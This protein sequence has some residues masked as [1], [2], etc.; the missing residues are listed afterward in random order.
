MVG[1]AFAKKKDIS[2][3]EPAVRREVGEAEAGRLLK[4]ACAL[5]GW[6]EKELGQRRKGDAQKV[7]L[8]SFISRRTG[9]PLS[10]MQRHLYTGAVAATSRLLSGGAAT[11]C[12]NRQT[13]NWITELAKLSK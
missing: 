1:R 13:A 10:W 5:W 12:W 4:R 3:I 6:K 8:A 7:I 11:D 9:V 2:L